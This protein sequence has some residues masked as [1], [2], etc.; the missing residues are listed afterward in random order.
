MTHAPSLRHP[1]F[2][3]IELLVVLAIIAVLIGLLLPAV[4]KV[5]EAAA[6][7]HC[8]NNLKQIG[9]ACHNANDTN[10]AMPPGI[11]W[12]PGSYPGS[13]AYGVFYFHLL[14]FVEQDN[15]YKSSFAGGFFSPRQNQVF[16][17]PIKT[18]VCPA[19]PSVGNNGTVTDNQN[20]TWG[21]GC[22]AANMQVVTR[23]DATTGK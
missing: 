20:V 10:G 11:G 9:L 3:L 5:R 7:S 18:F 15:L 16:A 12:Y 21:A 6:R 14:P 4:Q 17:A 13:R 23:C 22:Y 8:T 19:D 1:G 2:T